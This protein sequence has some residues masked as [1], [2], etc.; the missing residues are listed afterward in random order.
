MNEIFF[1]DKSSEHWSKIRN[2]SIQT[3][4]NIEILYV[5]YIVS[6]GSQFYQLNLFDIF[7]NL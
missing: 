1:F 4:S 6:G 5:T 7:T 2:Y 3:N